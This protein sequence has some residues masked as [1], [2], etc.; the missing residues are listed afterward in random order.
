MDRQRDHETVVDVGD[1]WT[2]RVLRG[3]SSAS[4][5]APFEGRG[6]HHRRHDHHDDDC[7]ERGRVDD[8]PPRNGQRKPDVGEDEPHLAAWD[9]SNADRQSV[10]TLAD[11]PERA[12]LLAQDGD[13]GERPR[14]TEHAPL[15][16]GAQLGP[17]PMST[18]KMGTRKAEMG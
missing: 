17:H 14:E 12:R 11:D 4:L 7:R 2:L 16:K 8:S 1:T 3:P 18:K 15:C 13:D 9:H 6:R 10:H 5:E